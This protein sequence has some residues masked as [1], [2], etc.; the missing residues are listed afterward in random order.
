MANVIGIRRPAQRVLPKQAGRQGEA[1]LQSYAAGGGWHTCIGI[2]YGKKG[3][4]AA[5]AGRYRAKPNGRD[6]YISTIIAA[7]AL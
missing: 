7:D 5:S 2:A 3:A 4:R 6:M 1:A